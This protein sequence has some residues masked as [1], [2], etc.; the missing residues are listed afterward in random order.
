[1]G[2][3]DITETENT[4]HHKKREKKP[5]NVKPILSMVTQLSALDFQFSRNLF[6]HS[7]DLNVKLFLEAYF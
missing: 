5:Q 1:M 7:K 3:F 2:I 4:K 6:I